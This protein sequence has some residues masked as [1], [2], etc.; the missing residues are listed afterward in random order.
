[1]DYVLIGLGLIGFLPMV[2]ILIRKKSNDRLKR[3]GVATTA[4]VRNIYG[5]SL[6]GI[7]IVR[8]EYKVRETG[9]TFSKNLRVA[10]MPYSVGDELPVI[11]DPQ[12]PRKMQPDMKKAYLPMLIFTII[13]AA[14]VIFACF[15]LKEMVKSGAL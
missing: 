5:V 4:V 7:N 3:H 12:K 8:V 11:Y 2:V 13:I 9:E 6:R 10:G 1:M 15:K 14:F